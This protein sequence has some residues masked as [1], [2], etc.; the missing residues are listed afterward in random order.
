[1]D[2]LRAEDLNNPV[3]LYPEILF[4]N[5]KHSIFLRVVP[6]FQ[7]HTFFFT[8]R[9]QFS[10]SYAYTIV[11]LIFLSH[12]SSCRPFG[13]LFSLSADSETFPDV[14][15]EDTM[16]VISSGILNFSICLFV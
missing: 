13:G 5:L 16:P 15:C 14:T 6:V 11:T 3:N 10:Y 9:L 1:M 7:Y 2:F 8:L 12:L 4:T